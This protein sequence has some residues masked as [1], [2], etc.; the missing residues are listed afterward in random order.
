MFNESGAPIL[1]LPRLMLFVMAAV[2]V[3]DN[4]AGFAN[5]SAASR[6][7]IANVLH[8]VLY[9]FTKEACYETR[10]KTTCG[11]KHQNHT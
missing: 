2:G 3:E 9:V 6:N 7:N 4:T 8:D 10:V 1:H 11:I 5:R